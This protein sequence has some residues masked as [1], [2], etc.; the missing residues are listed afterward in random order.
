MSQNR[1]KK[2]FVPP[3]FITSLFVYQDLNKDERTRI[4]IT[5]FIHKKLLKYF[6][7]KSGKNSKIHKFLDSEKGYMYIYNLINTFL[8]IHNYQWV[9]F[10]IY[11]Y[12]FKSY[13]INNLY[14][15]L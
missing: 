2:Y 12:H 11:Y 13:A 9:D 8:R 10:N 1:I 5:N 3:P 4:T 15:S 7:Q 6:H 14:E